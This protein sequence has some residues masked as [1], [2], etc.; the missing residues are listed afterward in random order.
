MLQRAAV[1]VLA[2][3]I[4][5]AVGVAREAGG[6]TEDDVAPVGRQCGLA[7]VVGGDQRERAAGQIAGIQGLLAEGLE[8]HH[9]AVGGNLRVARAGLQLHAA[10]AQRHA[11]HRPAVQVLDEHIVGAIG[12]AGHQVAGRALESHE[13]RVGRDRGE[14]AVAIG[15][16][17]VGRARR[18]ADAGAGQV[19][20]RDVLHAVRRGR[21]EGERAAGAGQHRCKI[22]I[23]G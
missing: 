4:V 9:V 13:A 22:V 15:R 7:G 14:A 12:V 8:Q 16:G 1:Q 2:K 21:S 11:A 3:H 17:A 19:G 10:G 6:G 23:A 5:V 18:E 20:H